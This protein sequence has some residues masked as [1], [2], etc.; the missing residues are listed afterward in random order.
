MKDLD[1]DELPSTPDSRAI[2]QQH[3]LK[4]A[5]MNRELQELNRL[6]SKKEELACQMNNNDTKMEAMKMQYEV[7]EL[8]IDL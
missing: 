3:V 8:C 2:S 1:S 4:Q 6:L 5:Q 7:L